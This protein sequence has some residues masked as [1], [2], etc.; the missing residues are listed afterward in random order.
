MQARFLQV[1]VVKVADQV[2]CVFKVFLQLLFQLIYIKS[3]VYSSIVE[4]LSSTFAKVFRVNNSFNGPL[5]IVLIFILILDQYQQRFRLYLPQQ[6]VRLIE[7]QQLQVKYRLYP[8]GSQ[9]RQ[10]FQLIYS[11]PINHLFNQI[12][13]K[14]LIIK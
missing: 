3:Y 8:A 11:S 14:V 2:L 6:G 9:G 1:C 12:G 10:E 7:V 4:L 13:A 5:L